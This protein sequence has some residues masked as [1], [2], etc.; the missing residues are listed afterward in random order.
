[1][2]EISIDMKHMHTGLGFLIIFKCKGFLGHRS[3]GTM[4]P[5]MVTTS[6]FKSGREAAVGVS[7][8]ISSVDEESTH[9][10]CLGRLWEW[11]ARSAPS[12][13]TWD[14]AGGL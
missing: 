14:C 10:R 13:L 8:R 3:L 9:G 7:L 4:A 6:A 5:A 11:G 1:M 12:A 2:K